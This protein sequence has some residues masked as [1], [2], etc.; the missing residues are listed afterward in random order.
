MFN[1]GTSL[2]MQPEIEGFGSRGGAR[3]RYALALGG[4]GGGE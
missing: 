2:G 3:S 1:V 4:G